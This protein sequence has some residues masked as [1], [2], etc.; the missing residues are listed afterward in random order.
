MPYTVLTITAPNGVKLNID[1]N[2]PTIQN[3]FN[4][5]YF[6]GKL[7]PNELQA[8]DQAIANGAYQNAYDFWGKVGLKAGL[9]PCKF[10]DE[11]TYLNNN[12]DVRQATK[13][14]SL[15][16]DATKVYLDSG[17]EH[18]LLFGRQEILNGGVVANQTTFTRA[19]AAVTP[20]QAITAGMSY[21]SPDSTIGEVFS[22]TDATF[23]SGTSINGGSAGAGSTTLN[24]STTL[25]GSTTL[26]SSTNV[27]TLN[28]TN[29]TTASTLNLANFDTTLTN[30]NSVGSTVVPVLNNVPA[31]VTLG[32]TNTN[33]GMTPAYAATVALSGAQNVNLTSAGSATAVPVV[34]LTNSGTG[35]LSTLNVTSNGAATSTNYVSLAGSTALNPVATFNVN[36]TAT[37]K[38]TLPSG[39]TAT[40]KT[41]VATPA[42]SVTF[43]DTNTGATGYPINA[44]FNTAGSTLGLAATSL[45]TSGNTVKFTG[46]GNTLAMVNSASVTTSS[47][48]SQF[49]NLDSLEVTSALA[50]SNIVNVNN[51]GTAIKN[52]SLDVA[53]GGSASVTNLTNNSTVNYGNSTAT[54]P[55]T[56]FTLTLSQVSPSSNNVV[57]VKSLGN[58]VGVATQAITANGV[59][60]INLTAPTVSTS[61]ILTYTVLSDLGT[62]VTLSGGNAASS[63][64]ITFTTLANNIATLDASASLAGINATAAPLQSTLKGSLSAANT[65]TGGSN[66][67][68][69]YGGSLADTFNGAGGINYYTGHQ[70]PGASDVNTYKFT[71]P[72]NINTITDFNPATATTACDLIQFSTS[73]TNGGFN[74][75]AGAALTVGAIANGNGASAVTAGATQV[76]TDAP[77]TLSATTSLLLYKGAQNTGAG[78]VTALTTSG[79]TSASAWTSGYAL[80]V[81]YLNADGNVHLG[82]V[83]ST[84]GNTAMGA[85]ATAFGDIAVLQGVTSL[86]NIDASDFALIA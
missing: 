39:L 69:L 32:L 34:A 36:G 59:G 7:S 52:V 29:T 79:L 83:K 74:V 23:V 44:T 33:F 77:L 85:G 86:A 3:L 51:F 13:G 43:A 15:N 26:G 27:G 73:S 81:A 30:I 56:G 70:V 78:I 67:D 20:A 47:V 5:Q 62:K 2:N 21:T 8:M 66:N 17:L 57:N 45:A 18:W 31:Q 49:T 76:Y 10:Y 84:A 19:T 41:V 38:V 42:A 72:N 58:A 60:T 11:S 22:G 1:T 64:Q 46:A 75:N 28:V 54:T 82:V 24:L 16:P 6:R 55:A 12:N 25:A 50:A 37:A 9:S 71:V 63:A 53:L 4:E 14:Q 65:L 35:A 40:T 68:M 48:A 61:N 80:P